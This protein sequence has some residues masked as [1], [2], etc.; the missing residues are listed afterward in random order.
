[1]TANLPSFVAPHQKWA[2]HSQPHC[3]PPQDRCE[4]YNPPGHG[5]N[6]PR[7]R[8]K[9]ILIGLC[10]L[11]TLLLWISIVI[12]LFYEISMC[13]FIPGEINGGLERQRR[14]LVR[15]GEYMFPSTRYNTLQLKLSSFRLVHL[16]S[17][18]CAI[19]I[20]NLPRVLAPL[21]TFLLL[22]LMGYWVKLDHATKESCGTSRAQ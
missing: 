13:W 17:G 16:T 18:Q 5:Q 15:V 2:Q 19:F 3:P 11:W 21:P 22:S 1:M 20:G 8:D 12:L 7:A 10:P 4:S 14:H 9:L 6:W